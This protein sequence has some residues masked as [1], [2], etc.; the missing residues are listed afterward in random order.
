MSLLEKASYEHA[1]AVIQPKFSVSANDIKEPSA[2]A[3]DLSGKFYSEVWM[4]GDR[5]IADEAIRQSEKESHLASKE[6]R[7]VEEAAERERRIGTFV[8]FQLRKYFSF[9]SD[10]NLYFG[11]AELSPPLEPYDPDTDLALKGTFDEIKIVNAAID[12][13]VDKLLNEAIE[14][15][16]KE[17]D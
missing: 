3:T 5:E 15:V 7:K 8:I 1:K 17:D 6:V 13:V 16:L 11:V 4:N 12:E 14:G 10:K 2:E 9:V